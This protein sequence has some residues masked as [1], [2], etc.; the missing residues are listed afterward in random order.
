M[1]DNSSDDT[2]KIAKEIY[3]KNKSLVILKDNKKRLNYGG[4]IKSCLNYAMKNNFDYKPGKKMNFHVIKSET[5]LYNHLIF[6]NHISL[7]YKFWDFP[8]FYFLNN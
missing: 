6:Y 1:D 7:N 2:L 8:S 4:N 5:L 3:K